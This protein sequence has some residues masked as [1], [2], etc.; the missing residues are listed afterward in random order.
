MNELHLAGVR[1][2]TMVAALL[3][4]VNELATSLVGKLDYV[5]L[6]RMNYH[7][8]DWLYKRYGLEGN[9]TDNFFTSQAQGL[10]A[11]FEEKGVDCQ[12]VF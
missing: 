12:V 5:L 2:F 6:D 10:T 1:T 7:Y 11:A 8:G 4:R 3:P 9:M